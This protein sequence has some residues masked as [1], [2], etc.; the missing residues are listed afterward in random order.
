MTRRARLIGIAALGGAVLTAAA[1]TV[2]GV[3]AQAGDD[4][5]EPGQIVTALDQPRVNGDALPS[6]LQLDDLG[7]G[8]VI[9]SSSR[10]LATD[11]TRR[12]WVARDAADDICLVVAAGDAGQTIATACNRPERIAQNGLLLGFQGLETDEAV[13]Y[14]L[15]DSAILDDVSG[16][17]Q[18][19]S[20]NVVVADAAEAKQHGSSLR[21]TDDHSIA[22]VP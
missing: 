13:V 1:L 2:G 6:S 9:A 22:L 5:L 11:D 4:T 17:W 12:F 3:V 15:P 18:V 21:T 14:L 19:L 20:P 16:P 8:G 7:N 10:L